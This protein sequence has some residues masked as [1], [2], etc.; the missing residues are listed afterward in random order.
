MS[1]SEKIEMLS[2]PIVKI[3]IFQASKREIWEAIADNG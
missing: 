1:A 2:C 3:L